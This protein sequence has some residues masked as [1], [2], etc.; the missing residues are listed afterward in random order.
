M[1]EPSVGTRH[2]TPSVHICQQQ[3][4]GASIAVA[5]VFDVALVDDDIVATLPEWKFYIRRLY[6]KASIRAGKREARA[7]V[8]AA[9]ALVF[10]SSR[11]S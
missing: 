11:L 8:H 1:P 6:V 7:S 5:A 3:K 10:D 9:N 4:N 2:A